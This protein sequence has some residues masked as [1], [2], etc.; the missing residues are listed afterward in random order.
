[1]DPQAI[2]GKWGDRVVSNPFAQST[3]AASPSPSPAPSPAPSLKESR[4]SSDS[5]TPLPDDDEQ[6]RL[7]EKENAAPSTA[8]PNDLAT[9][10]NEMTRFERLPDCAG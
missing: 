8:T 9:A 4:H 1:M 7:A 3:V 2:G 6:T 5:S 10:P